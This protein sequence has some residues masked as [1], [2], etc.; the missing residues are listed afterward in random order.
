MSCVS[1]R[2]ANCVSTH[3]ARAGKEGSTAA[4]SLAAVEVRSSF[5]K[6]AIRL[7]AA[8]NGRRAAVIKEH[9]ATRTPFGRTMA[10]TKAR[11]APQQV[12]A[13]AIY[14]EQRPANAGGPGRASYGS[15]RWGDVCERG[16]AK[17]R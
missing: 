11:A 5:S 6:P 14:P 1:R 9:V 12:A 8:T 10:D 3:G 17:T 4:G 15:E 2:S 16:G 7:V 13:V